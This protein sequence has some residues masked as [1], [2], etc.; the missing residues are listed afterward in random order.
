MGGKRECRKQRVIDWEAKGAFVEALLQGESLEEAAAKAG[1]SLEGMYGARRKDPA[2]RAVWEQALAGSA[3]AVRIAGNNGRCAQ[4]RKMRNVRFGNDRKQTFLDRFAGTCDAGAAAA[5]AGIDISTVYKHRA[6]DP[7]F[8]A[9]FD[10]ALA[11]G[12][13]RLEA[14]ALRQRIEAQRRLSDGLLPDGEIAEEFD[15]VLKLLQRWDRRGGRIGVRPAEP[16]GRHAWSFDEAIELLATKLRN[17]RIEVPPLPPQDAARYDE[18]D[19]AS[20]DDPEG[21]GG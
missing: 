9:L 17:M 15:R 1:F 18:S 3:R 6:K 13:V 4:L 10:E 20:G 2:F 11:H 12:Y 16:H 19:S 8:A 5:V 21:A 14:E 7:A